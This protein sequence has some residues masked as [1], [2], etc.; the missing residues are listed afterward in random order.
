MKRFKSIL[1]AT[2]G[3]IV[4]ACAV[5]TPASAAQADLTTHIATVSASALRLR[6]GPSTESSTLDYAANGE[7]VSI[8]GKTGSWYKVSYNLTDGYMHESHLL[9]HD[10]KNVELGY[11][12]VS[13]NKVNIRS[14]PGTS[15]TAV[16]RGNAGDKAYVIGFNRQ[17]YKV[18]YGDKI[19]YIRSDYLQLTEIPYEN[20][21]S[22][23]TPIFFIDGKSTGIIPSANALS[24]GGSSTASKIVAT[25][26]QYIGVPYEWGG[27]S[28]SGF[29]C[30]GF[31]Q[32]VF[33]KHSIALPR[34]T[35]QQYKVG[36]Y[37]SRSNLKAGDLVFLQNT[38]R[39]GISHV[40]IYVG[41][42]KMIHASSSKGIVISDLSSSYYT[43]HYY[44]ARRVL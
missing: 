8:K 39:E 1:A 4:I 42:G 31:T 6:S 28:P 34:T 26:K 25:A 5:V 7:Y 36:S 35:D 32:Y 23:K 15:Y 22:T 21:D 29:D 16:A 13:G 2:I 40:G 12:R 24:V 3:C 17:W 11:G 18:I 43:K 19:G 20:K 30:S 38:Y 44:G 37:V 33:N 41:D 27:S 9:L 10:A 14:G